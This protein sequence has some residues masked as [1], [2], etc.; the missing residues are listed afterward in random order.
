MSSL[1]APLAAGRTAEIFAWENDCVL[2]LT[3]PAFPAFLADQEWQKAEAAWKM[4]APAPRPLALLEVEGRR[5]V[6]FQRVTG[7]TMLQALERRPWRLDHFARQLGRLHAQLHELRAPDFPS[8]HQRVHWSLER[9]NRLPEQR[10]AGVLALLA[11]LPDD[12][13]LCHADF[14]PQNILLAESGP[15]VI[16]WEGSLHGAPGGDVANTCL[17]IRMAFGLGRGLTGWLQRQLGRRFE[18]VYLATYQHAHGPVDHLPEWLAIQAACQMNEENLARIPLYEQ[19]M[20][21][22]IPA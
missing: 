18:R 8:L 15:L 3:R 2:K 5:G 20:R 12:E 10:K 21:G 17:W 14:H 4:G 22:V 9:A 16:D 6:V 13:T 11:R 7:P 19:L 1:R